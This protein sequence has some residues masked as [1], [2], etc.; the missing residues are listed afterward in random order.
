[1][2]MRLLWILALLA[3]YPASAQ[4]NWVDAG[5]PYQCVGIR[6]LYGDSTMDRLLACG[7]LTL[8]NNFGAV[9]L[10]ALSSGAWDTLGT[11]GGWV[12]SAIRFHDTL[13]VGGKFNQVNN[14]PVE[15]VAAWYDGN[16]HSYGQFD[17]EGMVRKLRVVNG[18]LYA[19][20]SFSS[21]DGYTCHGVA[22]RVGGHWENIGAINYPVGD[23]PIVLDVCEYQGNIVVGG[24]MNPIGLGDDLIQFDG[25]NWVDVGDGLQ[26][27]VGAVTSLAVYQDELYV[28]GGLYV[29][30]GS[31]GH[32][33]ARWDGSTWSDVGGS[34]RDIYGTTQYNASASSLLVHDGKLLVGGAFG[35][36]GTLHANQFAIWDGQT[37]CA[38]GDS[39]GG[40]VESMAFY[41]DTLFIAC[42][43]TLNGQ[44]ANYIG[45]WVG[46]AFEQ[47]CE[48]VGME[49]PATTLNGG[50]T[51]GSDDVGR[52][53]LFGLPDGHYAVDLLDATG[54]I[55]TTET[56]TSSGG[57]ARMDARTTASGLYLVRVTSRDYLGV[58]RFI[59]AQ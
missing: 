51:I 39:I 6:Q 43:N 38:P 34:M 12:Y 5:M 49:E 58:A 30:A 19:V 11:F 31:L 14:I 18:E 13:L 50:F 24:E 35:Y 4:T 52:R 17:S 9:P 16:W 7:Q 33:L 2:A 29:G 55:V 40:T 47:N 54:R 1:M 21:V 56:V 15:Q 45:R 42:T 46:G 27:S 3:T 44:P 22:K 36:A 25:T 37:W 57:H 41:H 48:Q 20:G 59:N 53:A 10:V 32:G 26:G 28:G 8:T 23:E